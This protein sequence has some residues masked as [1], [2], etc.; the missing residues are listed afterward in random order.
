APLAKVYGN[1]LAEEE[2]WPAGIRITAGSTSVRAFDQPLR[3]AAATARLMLVGA[4]A[5]RWNV[6]PGACDTADGL[7][8]NGVR[9]FTFAELAEEAADRT[10]PRNAPLRDGAKRHLEGQPLQLLDGPAKAEVSW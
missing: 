9:T 2:G 5:D 6:D 4:A 7:V 3:E 8:L 1:P 10:P